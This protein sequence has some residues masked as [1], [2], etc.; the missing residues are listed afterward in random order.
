MQSLAQ[1]NNITGLP[2]GG[3]V[4]GGTI[5]TMAMNDG[6]VPATMTYNFTISQAAPWRSVFEASY[7]GNKSWSMITV[8]S[9]SKINDPNAAPL[10]SYFKPSPVTGV[11]PCIKGVSCT[12]LNRADYSLFPTFA[13]IYIAGHG[14]WANYNSLQLAWNKS[15]GPALF[16]INYAFGKVLGQRG[17]E[18]YNGAGTGTQIDPFTLKNNYGTLAY[19]H[20]HVFNAAYVF[21]LPKPVHDNMILKGLV[22][23][24]ELSG[25]TSYQSG[26]PIQPNTGGNLN[27]S[28]PSNVSNDTYLG[29]NAITLV[30]KVICDPTAGLKSGQRFNPA[31]FAPPAPGT[32]GDIIW[33]N[34]TGPGYLSSDLSLYKTFKFTETKNLQLRLQA[35]NFLNHPNAQFLLQGNNDL[36]LDFNGPN[37]TLA[38]TNQNKA[39]TGTPAFTVGSRFIE[40]AVK[41]YF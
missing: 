12:N 20:R 31:C 38:Q 27:V 4:N 14:G 32:N 35:Y 28:W 41:F 15:A 33:P 1:I 25:V 10:G 30:P 19:D 40:V 34:I 17:G 16:F 22:N 9:N 3:N 11:I 39:T 18:S 29:T 23:G 8:G 37:G 7:V 21:K 6:K 36:K 26:V 24:W 5:Y 13:D 2:A